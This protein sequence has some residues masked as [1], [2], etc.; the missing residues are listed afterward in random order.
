MVRIWL[1]QSLSFKWRKAEP[2]TN[3]NQ[4]N[5][6]TQHFEPR[7]QNA[8]APL[9]KADKM[10]KLFFSALCDVTNEALK[11][12]LLWDWRYLKLAKLLYPIAGSCSYS[13]MK[14]VLCHADRVCLWVLTINH[15]ISRLPAARRRPSTCCL[16]HCGHAKHLRHSSAFLQSA[17][18][19]NFR[20]SCYDPNCI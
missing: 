5:N 12:G 15:L 10:H 18:V 13:G 14:S 19:W 6:F 1:D 20:T 3:R 7:S 4:Q 8:T 2:N 16:K 11:M 17:A 9:L